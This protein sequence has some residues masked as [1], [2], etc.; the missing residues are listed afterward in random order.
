MLFQNREV[1]LITS[2]SRN[3]WQYFQKYSLEFK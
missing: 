1:N 3:F 2:W